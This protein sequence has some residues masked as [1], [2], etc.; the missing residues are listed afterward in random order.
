MSL[1]RESSRD[2]TEAIHFGRRGKRRSNCISDS[3]R[4]YVVCRRR[5]R[6]SI[7]RWRDARDAVL[8]ACLAIKKICRGIPCK[9]SRQ[10]SSRLL[11]YNVVVRTHRLKTEIHTRFTDGF[12]CYSK[13]PR[14]H[15]CAKSGC[16]I[17][18]L[19]LKGLRCRMFREN[20]LLL[21][22]EIE[23]SLGEAAGYP[24]ASRFVYESMLKGSTEGMLKSQF[25]W[26]ADVLEIWSMRSIHIYETNFYDRHLTYVTLSLVELNKLF[27][28]FC[29]KIIRTLRTLNFSYLNEFY[30]SQNRW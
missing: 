12:C 18:K 29:N 26:F 11:R 28:L 16:R 24:L 30:N 13:L 1:V 2:Y 14:V 21:F 22:L 10:L 27:I 15:L 3:R 4:S 8:C 25:H 6:I 20:L 23:V 5:D 17:V 7:K 9:Y 19:P